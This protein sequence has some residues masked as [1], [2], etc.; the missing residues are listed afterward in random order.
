MN[1]KKIL[2]TALILFFSINLFAQNKNN[3]RI[4][5]AVKQNTLMLRW[6]PGNYALWNAGNLNGYCIEKY[7]INKKTFRPVYQNTDT[8]MILEKKKW[9]HIIDTNDYAAIAAQAIF[10]EGFSVATDETSFLDMINI[11]KEQT[12]RYSFALLMASQNFTLAKYMGLGFSQKINPELIYLYKIF[13]NADST[14]ADTAYIMI[15]PDDYRGIPKIYDLTAIYTNKTI[16][17]YWPKIVNEDYFNNYIIERSTDSIHFKRINK[18][19]FVNL[20]NANNTKQYTYYDTISNTGVNY[21]YRIRGVDIFGQLSEYSDIVSVNTYNPL[22]AKPQITELNINTENKINVKWSFPTES[23]SNALGFQLFISS[24]VNSGYRVV[25]KNLLPVNIREYDISFSQPVNYIMVAVYDLGKKA[26]FSLPQM[27]QC[28]DSTP[29]M[30]PTGITGFVDSTGVMH[31]KWNKNTEPDIAGYR[32]FY[33]TDKNTDFTQITKKLLDDNSFNYKFPLNW[34]NKYVFVKILAEDV[35]LNFS[36]LSETAQ[37]ALYDTIAPSAPV[38]VNYKNT[39]SKIWIKWRNSSSNDVKN[40]AL[41]RKSEN[42]KIDTVIN[43]TN[44]ITEYTDSNFTADGYYK[45]YLTAFDNSGNHSVSN[46]I[47]VRILDFNK[48]PNFT[49]SADKINKCI[50][51]KWNIDNSQVENIVIYKTDNNNKLRLYKTVSGTISSL[52]DNNVLI[53]KTYKYKIA[54]IYFSRKKLF[55]DSKTIKL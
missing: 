11:S 37:I 17:L 28:K 15:K 7:I 26:L 54:V 16:Q 21:Y 8:I 55:S 30:P 52:T 2:Y 14:Y 46:T 12:N 53:N 25:N 43:F 35:F 45:Y 6:A 9:E 13:I 19:I 10:G 31:L 36:K 32:V 5:Y 38:I 27:I 22:K 41:C 33:S 20:E 4:N 51:I 44:N 39:K 42:N 1:N 24:S 47:S 3:I 23:E 40:T 34:L 18:N 29:P 48:K 50:V 49:L